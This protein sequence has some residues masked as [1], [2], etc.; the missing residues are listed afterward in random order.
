MRPWRQ[1][2]DVGRDLYPDA[3]A[4]DALPGLYL[5][6]PLALEIESSC[7]TDNS[8]E[9]LRVGKTPMSSVADIESMR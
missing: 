5:Q 4:D 1:I 8:V 2:P 7:V 6:H 9:S 3:H